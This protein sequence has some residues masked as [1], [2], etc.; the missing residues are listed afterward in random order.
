[1]NSQNID[2]I[3]SLSAYNI[4]VRIAMYIKYECLYLYYD[5]I[6]ITNDLVGTLNLYIHNTT[7]LGF[8]GRI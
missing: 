6:Y 3:K 5:M 7:L 2:L 4:K 8:K 1:M